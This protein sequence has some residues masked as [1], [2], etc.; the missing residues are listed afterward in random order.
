MS[1]VQAIGLA[2]LPNIGGIAGSLVTRNNIKQ[3]YEVKQ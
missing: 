2:I 1:L 3:W